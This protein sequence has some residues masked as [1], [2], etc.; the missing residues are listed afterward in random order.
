ME[1]WIITVATIL[2]PLVTLAIAAGYYKGRL[3][4]AERRITTLENRADGHDQ[5]YAR[6]SRIETH[7]EH[8][9]KKLES[10]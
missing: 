1:G 6:L 4:S 2:I 5:V 9:L 8:I 3:E 10:L 7:L